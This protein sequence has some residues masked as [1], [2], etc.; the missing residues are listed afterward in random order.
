VANQTHGPTPNCTTAHLDS[1]P[2]WGPTGQASRLAVPP[3]YTHALLLQ[4]QDES[5]ESK[6]VVGAAVQG[7]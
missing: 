3:G 1:D 2:Q 7:S 6:R 4:N 5:R